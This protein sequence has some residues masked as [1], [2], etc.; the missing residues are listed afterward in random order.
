MEQKAVYIV[1]DREGQ[2]LIGQRGDGELVFMPSYMLDET[3]ER[4]MVFSHQYR[5]PEKIRKWLNQDLHIL[6]R[7]KISAGENAANEDAVIAAMPAGSFVAIF[8]TYEREMPLH[9]ELL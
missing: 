1:M 3:G 5:L 4:A 6:M 2:V 8:S 9:F 7:T